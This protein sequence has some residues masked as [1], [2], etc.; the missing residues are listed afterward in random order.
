MAAAIGQ[1]LH[2]PVL[3]RSLGRDMYR[4]GMLSNGAF[5]PNLDLMAYL[6]GNLSSNGRDDPTLQ[7]KSYHLAWW[8]S[9][10]VPVE[11]KSYLRSVSLKDALDHHRAQLRDGLIPT[12]NEYF[13]LEQ[14]KLNEPAYTWFYPELE[15]LGSDC[16]RCRLYRAV[17]LGLMDKLRDTF[18]LVQACEVAQQA[19]KDIA[20]RRASGF[21]ELFDA[22]LNKECDRPVDRMSSG[23]VAVSKSRFGPAVDDLAKMWKDS[24]EKA[25]KDG[26][27]RRDKWISGVDLTDEDLA[28]LVRGADRYLE[29]PH[30]GYDYDLRDGSVRTRSE[31]AE[32]D[33]EFEIFDEVTIPVQ[34]FH[35]LKP[36]DWPDWTILEPDLTDSNKPD[37]V[38]ETFAKYARM[39]QKVIMQDE[40]DLSV[41]F[42]DFGGEF[43]PLH[44][45]IPRRPWL[46]P[47]IQNLPPTN[48]RPESSASS[49]SEHDEPASSPDTANRIIFPLSDDSMEIATNPPPSPIYFPIDDA[50][51]QDD[52]MDELISKTEYQP[53]QDSDPDD[54]YAS[55]HSDLD[56]Q[57]RN[58]S[59]SLRR[60]P[61]T[62]QFTPASFAHF[63]DD[64][65]G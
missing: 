30:S 15:T 8:L 50:D 22:A 25:E 11:P 54:I 7:V 55:D 48:C 31:R 21:H 49:T 23:S 40:V 3:I 5:R 62:G 61:T 52:P 59:S 16:T 33:S 60:D 38:I 19:E 58:K 53:T 47:S 65:L 36:D 26:G 35:D 18:N 56:M 34:P 6:D 37:T 42:W 9:N 44:P 27:K 10:F 20:I 2:I 32:W 45:L 1:P 28:K 4:V 41:D 39:Q 29:V 63:S 64:L 14:E 46:L 57:M 43:N 12:P 51:D 13:R 24:L 17:G